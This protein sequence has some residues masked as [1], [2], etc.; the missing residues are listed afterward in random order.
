MWCWTPTSR[1]FSTKKLFLTHS[2]RICFAHTN[3]G[4]KLFHCCRVWV[5][6]SGSI[7]VSQFESFFWNK[8]SF[9][10]IIYF[11]SPCY[12]TELTPGEQIRDRKIPRSQLFYSLVCVHC[13]A[14]HT[15]FL[16]DLTYNSIYINKESLQTKDSSRWLIIWAVVAY[17]IV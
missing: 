12:T 1:V 11:Y 4:T 7:W 14:A 15:Y 9:S 10:T 6:A 5:W 2:G 13:A 17:K 8:I 3:R 16:W